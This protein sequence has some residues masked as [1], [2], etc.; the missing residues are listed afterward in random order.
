MIQLKNVSKF[1]YSKGMIAS[2]ISKVNLTLDK[3]EFVV[4][5]GESGSGKSTLLNVISGLDSYEEGEMYIDG[6]ETSHYLASDFEEYRKKYIGNIFQHFNLVNSYTVYQNVELIL[7][8]NGYSKADTKKRVTEILQRVGLSAYAK[9]KVS[10]LSGG[11]KQRVSIARALAKDT[12]IIVADEPTGNLDST[13]AAGIVE[14]LSAI[15]RDKLVIV[16]THNFEQFEAYATRK[17]KMYDGKVVEDEKV[18]QPVR[19]AGE[20]SA[21]S[22]A[23]AAGRASGRISVPSK[24][25]LGL[26][27]TFNIVPKFLL[28]LVV[29]L[30]VVVA[31][32]SEYTSFQHNKEENSNL[33]YNSYFNNF[34]PDRV[35]LKKSDGSQFTEDDLKA[36]RQIDN[37]KS[38]AACDVLL[39]SLVSIEEGD[40]SYEAFPRP[41]SEFTGKLVDGRL[42]QTDNEVVLTGDKD[43]YYFTDEMRQELLDKDFKVYVSENK[44]VTVRIVGLA[45]KTYNQN[46]YVYGGDLFVSDSLL[47][48]MLENTYSVNSTVT[49]TINGKAQEAAEGS[50]TYRVVPSSKVAQGTAVASEEINNF[51][52]KGKAK[53]QTIS[54]AVKNIYYTESINLKVADVYTKKTFE[55]LTGSKDFESNNGSI[56][57]NPADYRSLFG[58]GNYQ[59]TVYVKDLKD[60][61]AT[62]EALQTMGFKTLAMKDAMVNYVDSVVSIIQVPIAVIII[63]ALFFIAYFVIRL[64]LR[65]RVSYFSILRMLGLARKN[66]RRILDVEM[67]TVINIAFALF[68]AVVILVNTGIIHV[69]YIRT[70]VEY[71]KVTDYVILYAILVLMGYLISGKFARSLFKKTAMGSFREEE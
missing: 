28:L 63:I 50:A 35:V 56:Y 33:G 46:S 26:R 16:V 42:P 1:Y 52:E 38:V 25:R 64:I 7:R 10:K 8:I 71:L 57:I 34:S 17:I 68:L 53:E 9:T 20:G 49:T 31:V 70:L 32:T 40:I 51:Y 65:S 21:L 23:A 3:G 59:A 69:E 41:V 29:F 22:F 30:F 58:K 15:S 37:I 18:T 11:Q 45:Y 14:L 44:E 5:T 60:L 12:D 39:D 36:I 2:G 67:F 4:I 55:K 62:K 66:I 48:D 43:D 6:K 47:E 13:S 54:V 61:N 24:I 19:T 27:N